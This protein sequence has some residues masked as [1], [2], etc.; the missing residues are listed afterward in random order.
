LQ[1]LHAG[2][3]GRLHASPRA[4]AA[5]VLRESPIAS[6]DAS[7][8]YNDLAIALAAQADPVPPQPSPH[9]PRSTHIRPAVPFDEH[10]RLWSAA[11]SGATRCIFEILGRIEQRLE[12]SEKVTLYVGYGLP[13]SA[14]Q[15]ADLVLIRT[16]AV[17]LSTVAHGGR[18]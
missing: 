2:S 12:A 5:P 13:S 14:A 17:R 11:R 1:G 16:I 4:L 9:R 15:G 8:G 7:L 3:R 6:D 10:Q 18:A